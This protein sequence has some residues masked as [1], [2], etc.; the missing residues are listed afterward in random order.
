M[1]QQVNDYE[2][3]IQIEVNEHRYDELYKVLN[4]VKTNFDKSTSTVWIA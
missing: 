2:S 1:T 3:V 4:E